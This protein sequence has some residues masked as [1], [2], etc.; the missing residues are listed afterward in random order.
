MITKKKFRA[1]IH[2]LYMNLLITTFVFY[3]W[4]SLESNFG[5]VWYAYGAS[6]LMFA[7]LVGFGLY[8]IN[9]IISKLDLE[10]K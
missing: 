9:T 3:K 2:G 5:A 8:K 4:F 10:E 1:L 7:S 6:F